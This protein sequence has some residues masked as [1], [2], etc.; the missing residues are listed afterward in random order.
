MCVIPADCFLLLFPRLAV[1]YSRFLHIMYQA[2]FQRVEKDDRLLDVFKGED[3][4]KGIE[5]WER[6]DK[7]NI[8]LIRLHVADIALHVIPHPKLTRALLKNRRLKL[9]AYAPAASG[10]EEIGL[11]LNSILN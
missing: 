3:R 11:F 5:L 2:R 7:D 6:W 4:E 8:Y 10:E 1:N 9:S